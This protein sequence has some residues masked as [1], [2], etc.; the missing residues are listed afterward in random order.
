M[1]ESSK[2]KM[3]INVAFLNS[4]ELNLH[5][6]ELNLSQSE[7]KQDKVRKEPK[8]ETHV[9]NGKLLIKLRNGGIGLPLSTCKNIKPSQFKHNPY[10]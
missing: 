10:V 3:K 6:S 9:F 7:G 5:L 8:S 4:E 2:G 1:G